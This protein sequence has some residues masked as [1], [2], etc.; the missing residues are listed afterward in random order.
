MFLLYW[1]IYISAIRYIFNHSFQFSSDVG[2]VN[3]IIR[4]ADLSSQYVPVYLYQFSYLGS[5]HRPINIPSE[6]NFNVV[7]RKVKKKFRMVALHWK[8]VSLLK[9]RSTCVH[10]VFLQE[11]LIFKEVILQLISRKIHYKSVCPECLEFWDTGCKSLEKSGFFNN[12]LN[13]INI[14]L[15]FGHVFHASRYIF[16]WTKFFI[17]PTSGVRYVWRNLIFLFFIVRR[18]VFARKDINRFTSG[19]IWG[20]V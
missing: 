11:M 3:G 1:Y 15:E 17:L 16:W 6:L 9:K 2:L 14:Y 18:L 7:P 10:W 20:D 5:G 13:N 12:N 4:Q 19:L 8:E